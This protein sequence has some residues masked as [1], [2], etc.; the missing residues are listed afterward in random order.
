MAPQVLGTQGEGEGALRAGKEAA[1]PGQ[2]E[3]TVPT[4][5]HC[6]EK[7]SGVPLGAEAAGSW[8]QKPSPH[9]LSPALG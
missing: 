4:P 6:L 1:K 5:A 3:G 8:V 2:T 9:S 7:G